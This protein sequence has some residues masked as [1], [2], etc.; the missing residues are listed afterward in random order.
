MQKKFL[1]KTQIKEIKK[2]TQEI[3]SFAKSMTVSKDKLFSLE[4]VIN[5]ALSNAVQYG[6]SNYK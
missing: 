5:E 1:I 6:T 3:M 2:T 4:M